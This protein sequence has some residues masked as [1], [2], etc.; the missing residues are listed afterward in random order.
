MPN[1]QAQTIPDSWNQ[2][3][4]AV[5]KITVSDLEP[6]QKYYWEE[7]KKTCATCVVAQ[8][9]Q[10]STLFADCYD[11]NSDG[12]IEQDIGPFQLPGWYR[13]EISKAKDSNVCLSAGNPVIRDFSVGGP[14]GTGCCTNFPYLLYDRDKNDCYKD[15]LNPFTDRAPTNCMEGTYCEPESLE[16]F[17]EPT[18]VVRGKICYDRTKDDFDKNKHIECGSSGGQQAPGCTDSV[19]NPGIA[20]AIG[21]IHTN[22]TELV[23]DL[24]KFITGIAGGLAFLMMLLGAFQML[25]SAGNPDTLNAGRERL[26]SAVIGLLFVIF[27]VLLLQIIGVDILKIPG[28]GR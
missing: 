27:A 18:F 20:T 5:K 6:D 11:S 26:T 15:I 22:P 10:Y 9:L 28:F 13:L 12:Q 23:K 17:R 4:G 7:K 25:T 14:T 16:C 1:L 21:C 8:W 2:D 3:V 19:G 24:L